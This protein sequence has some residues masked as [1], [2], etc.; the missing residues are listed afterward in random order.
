LKK[1]DTGGAFAA[2]IFYREE[3]AIEPEKKHLRKKG[4]ETR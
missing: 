3:P 1:T 4:I 2:D